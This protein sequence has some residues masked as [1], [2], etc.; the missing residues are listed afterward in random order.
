MAKATNKPTTSKN[1]SYIWAVGRRKRAVARIRLYEKD[2][3]SDAIDIE[4]NGKPVGQYF[5]NPIAK[6]SYSEPLDLTKTTDKYRVT[7]KVVGSGLEGQ[8][9]A[10]K[11]GIARALVKADADHKPVLRAA[12]LMTRDDRKKETRKIGHG[13]KARAKKQSPKR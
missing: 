3:K 12:G 11:H 7:V 8:L 13:G 2:K 10:V 9:D 6:L 4:V 5:H 1:D